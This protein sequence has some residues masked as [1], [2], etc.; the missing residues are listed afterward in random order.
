MIAIAVVFAACSSGYGTAAAEDA[1]PAEVHAC[2][3]GKPSYC[4]KYGGNRC[5][6]S[7]AAADATTACAKW[8]EYC[9]D[10]QTGIHAC[11]DRFGGDVKAG[12]EAC[13]TCHEEMSACMAKID[14]QYWPNR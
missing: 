12:S 10:C 1:A 7:N 4:F 3:R 2:A 5:K 6:K 9:L 13:N 8:V 14:K 11:F